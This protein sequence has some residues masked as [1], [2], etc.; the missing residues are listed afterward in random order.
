MTVAAGSD[1]NVEDNDA[2]DAK[3]AKLTKNKSVPGGRGKA[4][5]TPYSVLQDRK[6]DQKSGK[7][8]DWGKEEIFLETPPHRGD[9][10]VNIAFGFTLLWLPL[11][12]AAIGRAAFVKYKFTNKR[13]SVITSAP[14]K[15]EELSASY[16]RIQSVVSIGRGVGAWGDMVITLK[17][18]S[19]VEMRALPRHKEVEAY[20]NQQI[21]AADSSEVKSADKKTSNVKGFGGK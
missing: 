14:W 17:D 21:K 7:E 13:I 8:K 2:F 6:N 9:L 16:S 19:K 18:G 1:S 3:L 20:I 5:E 11:T 10:A 12:A 4:R 15:N